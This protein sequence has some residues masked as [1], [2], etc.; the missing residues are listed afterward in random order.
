MSVLRVLL[1]AICV[2]LFVG[3]LASEV[4]GQDYATVYKIQIN[5]DN[6][7]TW[8][9]IKVQ[10][11]NGTIDSWEGFRQKVSALVS[12]SVNLTQRQMVIDDTS[13]QMATTIS[14]ETQ[15]K[16]TKYEFIWLNFTVPQN[17]QLYLGDVFSNSNL[18]NNLY[19]E[20]TLQIVYPAN[21]FVQKVLPSPNYY[22]N[23]SLIMTWIRTQDFVN[24]KPSILFAL[25]STLP[26]PNQ[27]TS[28]ITEQYYVFIGLGTVGLVVAFL[29]SVLL[30]KHRKARAKV[31]LSK[32]GT[33]AKASL[34]ETEEDKV[35]KLVRT[36]S[37]GMFQ[38]AITEQCRFS[39]AKTSQ[40]LSSLEQKGIVRRYKRG[41]DK[42]VTIV[43]QASEE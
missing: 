41:R 19:G 23:T 10:D 2:F 37:G 38:S 35:L 25:A 43:D 28:P 18:F 3:V 36:N 17:N 12:E 22:L 42:I 14:Q 13:L 24:G 31:E 16:T 39:K 40:L 9:I 8:T 4:K 5:S 26:S 30:V 21:Y 7:A 33:S 27:N 15:S 34:F 11:I 32:V 29:G 20:G 1:F 6:S